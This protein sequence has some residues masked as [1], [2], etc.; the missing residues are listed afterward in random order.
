MPRLL[1]VFGTRPEAIK[2]APVIAAA[3]RRP[4]LEARIA[5]TAQHRGMLDQVLA[6]FSLET[7]HDLDLMRPGQTLLE[8]SSR[9]LAGLEPVI[10]EERPDWVVVQ[11][12]TATAFC[13]AF[14][15]FSLGIPVAHVE[16]G[17]RT[18]D[19][20]QP[21]PEEMNR[22]LIGRLAQA[23]FA[24]TQ[25]GAANLRAE[26]V[27]ESDILVTGNTGI[28]AILSMADALEQ[29]RVKATALPDL[30]PRK[31]LIVVTAHRRESFGDGMQRIAEAINRLA[32]REDVE[33]AYP[34]H[35]NPNVAG[36]MKQWI[37]PS[38]RVH[39]MEP[40]SYIPF[41]ELMRR[42]RFLLTDSGGIQEEAPALGKP[43]LVLR[44]KTERQ[45]AVEAGTARLVGTDTEKIVAESQ[46]LLDD[47]L[48][49]RQRSAIANPF[50]D[51]QASQRI[52]DF[53]ATRKTPQA[54]NTSP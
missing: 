1:I 46:I 33:I 50:G 37:R 21:F 6:S 30:D 24:P 54:A 10:V 47:E 20:R 34:V 53:L 5:V 8:T 49:Y 48:V 18:G 12:D 11:G 22:V 4:D 3:R 45:E 7:H 32:K 43:V 40:L 27:A 14:A 51:G 29:G 42:C 39:L 23:H 16:A 41:V 31:K 44:E 17:L 36:A 25:R 9:M 26:G 13:G 19:I 38:P 28:D 52:A 35:P 2:L 15:A